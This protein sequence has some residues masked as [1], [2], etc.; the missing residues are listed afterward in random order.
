MPILH[1]FCQVPP[2]PAGIA[3]DNRFRTHNAILDTPYESEVMFIGTFNPDIDGNMADFFY[4]RNYF[5]T[6]LKNLFVHN[7]IVIPNRRDALPLLNPTLPEIFEL[8]IDKSLTFGDL[9]TGVLHNA[10]PPNFNL[11]PGNKVNIAENDISLIEDNGLAALG[12]MGQLTWNTDNIIRY[13]CDHPSIKYIYFTRQPVGIWAAHW[14]AITNHECMRGRN[15]RIIQSPTALGMH[16][17]G[18]PAMNGLLHR[19]VHFPNQIDNGWLVQHGVTLA[20]F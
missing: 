20:N 14:N 10:P 15:C 1:K 18:V 19:W 12:A 6:A 16:A 9:I 11:V 13:L 4:G 3:W 2:V 8:C 17:P 7:A 5:W